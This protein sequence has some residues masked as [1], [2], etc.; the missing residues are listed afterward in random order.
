MPSPTFIELVDAMR[1]AQR[2]YFRTRSLPDLDA[3]RELER[4]VDQALDQLTGR[5]QLPLMPEVPHA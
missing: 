3:A 4:R 2:R 1:E 5:T